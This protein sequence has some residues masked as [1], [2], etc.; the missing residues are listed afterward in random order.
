VL[1]RISGAKRVE[2][3]QH[4][5]YFAKLRTYLHPTRPEGTEKI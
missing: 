4:L 3:I 2:L 5:S 1:R